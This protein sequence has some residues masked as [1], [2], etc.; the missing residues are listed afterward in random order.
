M[1]SMI[2][3][4]FVDERV[5]IVNQKCGEGSRESESEHSE[6]RVLILADDIHFWLKYWPSELRRNTLFE[7]FLYCMVICSMLSRFITLSHPIPF[8][9]SSTS[10]FLHATHP[11]SSTLFPNLSQSARVLSSLP[12]KHWPSRD[13]KN[14]IDICSYISQSDIILTHLFQHENIVALTTRQMAKWLQRL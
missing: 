13:Q 4:I 3:T 7:Y 10:P 14:T 12:P 2:A 1:L 8:N 6:T 9:S 11:H 5:E